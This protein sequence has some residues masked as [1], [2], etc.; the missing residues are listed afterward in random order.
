MIGLLALLTFDITA[1][2]SMG[3]AGA[4]VVAISVL[5]ALTLLPALL[6]VLGRRV[7][8]LA[9]GP[10]AA[11]ISAKQTNGANGFWAR[12]AHAVMARP[13]MV[14]VPLLVVLIGLGLPFLRVE[15]GAP[16][17]SI[18][19]P[20][21]QSRRGFDLLQTHW[22]AGELAPV[23]LVFQTT[24]GSSPLRPDHIQ[25]LASFMRRV[26]ADSRVQRVDSV[27]NLDPR[28]TPEQYALIFTDPNH[29]SDAYA[30]LASR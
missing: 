3:A 25:A 23:L 1:L 18:L 26:Q 28:I 11:R 5:A 21:V 14:L 15:L 27:V 20:D 19:P 2:R 22:G 17:A 16:D 7:D 29:I 13:L 4:L 6:S 30:Q 24:D 8:A 9:I 10:L 12:L